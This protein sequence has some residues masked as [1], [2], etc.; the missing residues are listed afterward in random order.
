MGKRQRSARVEA[1]GVPPD[2]AGDPATQA[3]IGEDAPGA[4]ASGEV[5][6]TAGGAEAAGATLV[7]SPEQA[8]ERLERDNEELRDRFL[9]T[10]ADLENFRKRTARERT[11]MWGRAQADLLARILDALDDLARVARLDPENTTAGALHEGLGLVERKLLRELESA[12]VVRL[13]PTGQPFDPNRHEAVMTAPAP[14]PEGDHTVGAVLQHGY[15][16]GEMLLRP[17]RVQV[18]TWQ[19]P[20]LPPPAEP[21]G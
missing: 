21:A 17:A 5:A 9:R 15:L 10:A 8:I 3:E 18:L 6:G 2:E 1:R 19:E 11:E 12:G 20:A 7:E 4:A 13:D 14:S 16:L